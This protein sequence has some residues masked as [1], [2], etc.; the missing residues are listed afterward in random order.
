MVRPVLQEK[1]RLCHK[2]NN[3]PIGIIGVS[4]KITKERWSGITFDIFVMLTSYFVSLISYRIYR[5]RGL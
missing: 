5:W 2:E 4:L 3:A 1:I